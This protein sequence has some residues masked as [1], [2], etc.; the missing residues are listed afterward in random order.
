MG[1]AG[2]LT[3]TV[4]ATT[5]AGWPF[6]R[7]EL[8]AGLR[9]YLAASSL[10]LLDITPIPLPTTMP[11]AAVLESGTTL[12]AMSVGVRIDGEDQSL[13]LLLKEPPVTRNGRVLRAIGQREYGVYRRLAPHLPLLVPGLVAGDETEGWII[14]EVLT[15]LR[16]APEWTVEDY[17]EAIL[18]LVSMHD[19]FWG[20][21]E[22]LVNYPWLARTLEAD[23]TDTIMAAVDAVQTLVIEERL[24]QI[25]SARYLELFGRLTRSADEVV[26][27]LRA[28]T[29]TLI[30][31]DYWPGNIARPIDGRQIVF[32]WQLAGIG[33]AIL[34]LVGFIQSVRMRLEP[35]LS[36]EEMIDLY[37]TRLEALLAP[38]WDNDRFNDLWDHALMWLFLV[39]WLGKLATMPPDSYGRIHDAF[40]RVWLE[41]LF[42]AVEKHL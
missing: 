30:H 18:N 34:D 21:A 25:N 37:R 14:L 26:A 38:G 17:H 10:R 27:P 36:A 15:G 1:E 41:P 31:G 11:G 33:P 19:R 5:E 9:R 40:S 3:Q 23:Y 32:D 7:S 13:P 20:L 22:D 16:P 24:P 6:S 4:S 8:T 2:N 42:N 12:S 35:P 39:N 29:P 28:E